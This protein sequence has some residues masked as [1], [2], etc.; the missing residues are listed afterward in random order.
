MPTNF[1]QFNP[2]LYNAENDA[3]YTGDTLR[4]GGIPSA[5][6]FPSPLANKLFYQLSTFIAAFSQMMVNKGYSPNDASISALTSVLMNVRC[7][8]DF[9]QSI[10][11]VP[12]SSSVV[13]NAGIAAQFDLTLTGNVASAS[14]TNQ[15]AGQLLGF[16]ISQDST[17]GRSF[18]WPSI[19]TSPGG[20]CQVA[21]STSIQ[22]FV[23]RPNGA[24]EPITQMIW[25]T[26]TGI[27]LAT[28]PTFFSVASSGSVA[29][30][31]DWVIEKADASSGGF[32]RTLY[33]AIGNAGRQVTIKKMD[34][35]PY[36]VVTLATFGGG[37]TIDGQAN[38]PVSMQYNA[39]T[40]ICD[41]SN[42]NII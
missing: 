36:N 28:G 41:G 14:I 26:A 12:C 2:G 17:G 39:L 20:I 23:V 40:V 1:L 6:I 8:S 13:F 3:A 37:Q 5:A 19:L 25:I 33:T 16:I 38:Y 34:V 42:W 7:G 27:R 30:G 18:V 21:G 4:S 22:Y 31:Y 24:I 32:T 9:L 15:T 35:S 10:V 11:T 29:S